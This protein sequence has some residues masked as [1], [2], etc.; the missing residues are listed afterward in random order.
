LSLLKAALKLCFLVFFLW[1]CAGHR[2]FS[3]KKKASIGG[4][5]QEFT[6]TDKKGLILGKVNS[7]KKPLLHEVG[8][9][10]YKI[11]VPLMLGGTVRCTVKSKYSPPGLWI[12]SFIQKL[13]EK[14]GKVKIGKI[15]AGVLNQWPYLYSEVA[16]F[17]KK[18]TSGTVKVIG[19]TKGE[20]SFLC[21]HTEIKGDKSFKRV[22][23]DLITSF[24]SNKKYEGEFIKSHVDITSIKKSN[25]GFIFKEIYKNKKGHFVTITRTSLIFP[26]DKKRKSLKGIYDIHIEMSDK[27]GTYLGGSYLGYENLKRKYKINVIPSNEKKYFVKGVVA[28]K[29]IKKS[30]EIEGFLITSIGQEKIFKGINKKSKKLLVFYDYIPSINP[31][32]IFKSKLIHK[33]KDKEGLNLFDLNLDKTQFKIKVD[34]KGHPIYSSSRLGKVFIENR[35]VF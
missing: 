22:V 32:K 5:L 4:T 24:K 17:G 3:V 18:I 33:G 30:F 29:K 7:F 16:Y 10:D 34:Q 19:I 35:R 11:E 2:G 28:G 12:S 25:V 15:N 9:G 26:K 1:S 27:G 20:N 13:K 6:L 31:L 8:G 14:S 21:L 23:R